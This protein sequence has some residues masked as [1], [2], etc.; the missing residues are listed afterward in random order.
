[1]NSVGF[2][3]FFTGVLV[4]IAGVGG[5]AFGHRGDETQIPFA[6]VVGVGGS[7]IVAGLKKLGVDVF[8][9]DEILVSVD[10]EDEET[11]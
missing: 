3:I 8:P 5:C 11:E 2:G 7:I 4:F 9:D 6:I 1:V 10:E